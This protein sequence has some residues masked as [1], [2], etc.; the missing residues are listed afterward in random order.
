MKSLLFFVDEITTY[1]IVILF[2]QTGQLDA[3]LF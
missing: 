2:V 1:Y 3:E